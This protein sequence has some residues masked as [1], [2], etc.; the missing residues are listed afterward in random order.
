MFDPSFTPYSRSYRVKAFLILAAL[1]VAFLVL[2]PRDDRTPPE[3][4][5]VTSS[6]DSVLAEMGKRFE[7]V[8]A[9]D[10]SAGEYDRSLFT[11][12]LQRSWVLPTKRIIFSADLV[13]V[14]QREDS[15]VA[16]FKIPSY[17]APSEAVYFILKVS[18]QD[19][20]NL[21]AGRGARSL[22]FLDDHAV[23][24]TISGVIR[25]TTDLATR[26]EENGDLVDI[27]PET[28][29]YFLASGFLV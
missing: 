28:M 15:Y 12:D 2:R 4:L 18:P 24:A 23:V 11:V 19:L 6:I 3:E 7:A 1:V 26:V 22:S 8:P 5:P 9:F 20:D 27:I 25:H 21:L 14:A 10:S 13:D 16:V 17:Q 29:D